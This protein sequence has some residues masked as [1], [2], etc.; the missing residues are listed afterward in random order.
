MAFLMGCVQGGSEL[1]GARHPYT[2]YLSFHYKYIRRVSPSRWLTWQ[3][4]TREVSY[5]FKAL[6]VYY[7]RSNGAC[8][9]VKHS[10]RTRSFTFEMLASSTNESG[11]R[12]CETITANNL[13]RHKFGRELAPFHHNMIRDSVV[14]ISNT[15]M[16]NWQGCSRPTKWERIRGVAL[17]VGQERCCIGDDAGGQVLGWNSWWTGGRDG[18]G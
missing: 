9:C 5:Y 4:C 7:P 2:R 10:Q 18:V 12:S 8:A 3:S 17:I 6:R 16:G 1:S 14:G 11:T 13:N 15:S